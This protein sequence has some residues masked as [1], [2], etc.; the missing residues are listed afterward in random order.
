MVDK[1]EGA[2]LSAVYGKLW[3]H[4]EDGTAFPM[5]FMFQRAI[6]DKFSLVSNVSTDGGKSITFEGSHKGAPFHEEI[7]RMRMGGEPDD[8]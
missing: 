3:L 5:E 4:F 7:M 6:G 1:K 2:E 8:G